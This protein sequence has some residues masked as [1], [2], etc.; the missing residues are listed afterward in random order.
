MV[1]LNYQGPHLI[2]SS[3]KRFLPSELPIREGI[4][5]NSKIFFLF[6]NKNISGGPSLEPSRETV[7]MK[8]HNG[9]LSLNY[10]FTPSYLEH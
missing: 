10:S 4:K 9:K 8:G 5:D 1:I 3:K 6:L 7:I 2:W